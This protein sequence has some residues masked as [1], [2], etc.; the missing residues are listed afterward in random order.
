MHEELLEEY[1]SAIQEIKDEIAK[2]NHEIT[3][4]ENRE[5]VE[6]L[7]ILYRLCQKDEKEMEQE[8]ER[9]KAENFKITEELQRTQWKK[10]NTEN[11]LKKKAK[12]LEEENKFLIGDQ[13]FS[14]EKLLTA[15]S[16][17][18]VFNET[19]V[20]L[21]KKLDCVEK[22]NAGIRNKIKK[23]EN[24]TKGLKVKCENALARYKG[25]DEVKERIKSLENALEK[26]DFVEKSLQQEIKEAESRLEAEKSRYENQIDVKTAEKLLS[27]VLSVLAEEKAKITDLERDLHLKKQH[28]QEIRTYG[29]QSNKGTFKLREELNLVELVLQEKQHYLSSLSKEI[30]EVE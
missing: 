3:S 19:F 4:Q 23:A 7:Q 9:L 11:D 5:E 17:Q 24:D 22:V 16:D 18:K 20:A 2:T 8:L 14:I 1:Q 30:A 29:T 27:E 12:E 25:N 13:N 26:F 21:Q 10:K 28:L 15:D 6:K